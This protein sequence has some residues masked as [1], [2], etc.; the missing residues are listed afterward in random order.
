[1]TL[2]KIDCVGKL[3][4]ESKE[5]SIFH[6]FVYSK[7]CEFN[8]TKNETD[9]CSW[10]IINLICEQPREQIFQNCVLLPGVAANGAHM[11]EAWISIQKKHKMQT[12]LNY[13]N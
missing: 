10:H 2:Q 8:H 5:K 3:V 11:G 12:I 1:M 4:K 6:S 13:N 9:H 7:E